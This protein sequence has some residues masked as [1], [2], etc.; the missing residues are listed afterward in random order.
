MGDY[1][2]PGGNVSTEP[3]LSF[4]DTHVHAHHC[5]TDLD[6]LCC[7]RVLLEGP[8]CSLGWKSCLFS[9]FTH[10]VDGQRVQIQGYCSIVHLVHSLTTL[11][12]YYAEQLFSFTGP[13]S[14]GLCCKCS[15][16][17]IKLGR[18][19]SKNPNEPPTWQLRE[20]IKIQRQ[21]R[22]FITHIV[23]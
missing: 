9:L 21:H 20:N 23:I 18:P 3:P 2:A 6:F 16:N 15:A 11:L 12:G 10:T 4:P 7:V 13:Q 1:D 19:Y 22:S 14:F 17:A 8:S 5:N